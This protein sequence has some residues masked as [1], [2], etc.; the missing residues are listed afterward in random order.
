MWEV[1]LTARGY[2]HLPAALARQYFP[3]DLLIVLARGAELW[4]LPVEGPGVIGLLLTRRNRAGDRR[5]FVAKLLPPGTAPGPRRSFWDER[6][7]VLRV[8]LI[9][10]E[11]PLDERARPA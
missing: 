6:S 5:L 9:A 8:V 10:N 11:E 4:L 7:G 2:L 1:N 3:N